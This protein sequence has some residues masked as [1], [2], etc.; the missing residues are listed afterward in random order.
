MRSAHALLIADPS[1]TGVWPDIDFANTYA[2][3][4]LG[5]A[6][7]AASR[8]QL[9][10]QA[11]PKRFRAK[12]VGKALRELDRLLDLLAD[13]VARLWSLPQSSGQRHGQQVL[14]N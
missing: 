13:E 10:H 8:A 9:A 1:A 12:A 7:L 6:F 11:G 2:T 5:M 4:P 14:R 3:F